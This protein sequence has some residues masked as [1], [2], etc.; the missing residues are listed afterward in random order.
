MTT[1]HVPGRFLG[2]HFGGVAG[3][4]TVVEGFFFARKFSGRVGRRH[5]RLRRVFVR[6]VFALPSSMLVPLWHQVPIATI[7]AFSRCRAVRSGGACVVPTFVVVVAARARF[8]G[9]QTLS[10]DGARAAGVTTTLKKASAAMRLARQALAL[11]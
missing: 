10:I 8:D 9:G 1:R 7:T 11:A 6:R 4:A 2:R 5:H 3:A